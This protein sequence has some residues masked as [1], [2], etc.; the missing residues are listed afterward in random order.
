MADVKGRFVWYELLTTN[1]A[2]AREFYSKVVG[3]TPKDA[4]MPGMEYWL[5]NM[6]D[7]MIAGVMDLPEQARSMGAPP[8][9]M[10][11][12]AVDDVDASAAAVTAA[13]GSI[14]MPAADIPN[15]GRFA[16]IADP[17]GATLSLF[18]SVN[19]EQDQT[20]DQAA[21][22]RVGWH[23]LF[24]GNMDADW[25]FYSGLFGWVKK[26]SMDM[27]PHGRYDMFGTSDVTLGGMMNKMPEMPFPAWGYYFNVEHINEAAEL[28]KSAGGQV[29]NGPMEVPGGQWALNGVDPQGVHFS[30]VGAA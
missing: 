12:V 5:F 6:G 9:W 27:G 17:N 21:L 13:G 23:E 14:R 29:V 20:A 11:Y 24:A 10:G 19:P 7:A 2:G 15:V 8:F 26:E 4:E 22:G 3:W 1:P 30:L 28:V 16:V 25:P 18:R